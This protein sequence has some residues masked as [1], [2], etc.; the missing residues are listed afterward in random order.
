MPLICQLLQ[1]NLEEQCAG[2]DTALSAEVKELVDYIWNEATGSLSEVLS[3]PV[4]SLKLEDVEKAEANL[5]SLRRALELGNEG[6][7]RIKELSDE[8][9]TAIPHL[10]KR[11]LINSKALIAQKQ[12][13]CQVCKNVLVLRGSLRFYSRYSQTE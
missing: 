11:E 2:E 6:G 7:A 10:L 9:Y 8:F 1:R 12:D 4:N 5:L 13:L 3:V